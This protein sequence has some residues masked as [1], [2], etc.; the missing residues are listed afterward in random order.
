MPS[1]K[2]LRW[3]AVAAIGLPALV[4]LIAM[5]QWRWRTLSADSWYLAAE[6]KKVAEGSL[7]I[8]GALFTRVNEHW[9][10][11]CKVPYYSALHWLGADA[12]RVS[13]L[14]WASALIAMVWAVRRSWPWI[15]ALPRGIAF[16]VWLLAAMLAFSLQQS[17]SWQW[18]VCFFLLFPLVVLAAMISLLLKNWPWPLRLALAAV[19]GAFSVLT[20]GMGVAVIW[21]VLPMLWIIER[22]SRLQICAVWTAIAIGFT[23]FQLS[24]VGTLKAKPT[25]MD[26]ITA[27][28][29][30][31][32]RFV[33]TL[34]GNPWCDGT[35]LDPATLALIVGSLGCVVGGFI[36]YALWQR[37]SD[38]ALLRTAAP[39]IAWVMYGLAAAMMITF[40][41]VSENMAVAITGRYV[42]LSLSFLAGL[43]FLAAMLWGRKKY[44]PHV[45]LLLS[46]L[47]VLS[48]IQGADE[49]RWNQARHEQ[50]AAAVALV[51]QVHH[52][53][54]PTADH[55]P[56]LPQVVPFLRERGLLRRLPVV[57]S[58]AIASFRQRSELVKSRASFESLVPAEGGLMA[59]GR[60]V[61][62]ERNA[63]P[64]LILFSFESATQPP[65]IID[66]TGPVLPSDYFESP[67]RRR[68]NA[69]FY[70]S[71]RRLI[72]AAHIPAGPG[73]LR[74][75]AWDITTNA[76]FP[77]QGRWPVNG[78]AP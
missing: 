33:I 13:L 71:W 75:W 64:D 41:R 38:A 78:A 40:G 57:T 72:P 69:N 10:V 28:P 8:L 31:A 6:Y 14:G 34:L 70:N 53:A 35:A 12:G 73:W 23:I 9:L 62:P 36:T 50:E 65:V 11:T 15:T 52:L 18:D 16:G 20:F 32:V 30:N 27:D 24:G 59:A 49:M 66:T 42:T 51:P 63:P 68:L 54:L 61:L 37:R 7:S 76:L 48:W 44:F 22:R 77:I 21:A 3:L 19:T 56:I 39:W 46:V 43:L 47:S 60:A 26:L 55:D 45:L 1:Q 29:L 67:T 4:T 5:D 17:Y 25:P 74:A 58:P 2:N